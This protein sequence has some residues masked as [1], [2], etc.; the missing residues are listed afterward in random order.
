MQKN[1]AIKSTARTITK[2]KLTDKIHS[3]KVLQKANLRC[4]NESVASIMA[5]TVWKAKKSMN[6]LGQIF[7]TS[8]AKMNTRASKNERL[9]SSVPGHSEA[10]SNTLANLWNHLDL[11]SANSMTA[12]K[13][14]AR[15]YFKSA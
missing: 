14:L 15:S 13:T 4:L 8:S 12:A 6:P 1:K 10:A 2:T 5:V 3:E 7:E 11:K 9:F